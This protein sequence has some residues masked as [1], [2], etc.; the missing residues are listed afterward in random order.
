M[1]EQ[2]MSEA[3]E[4]IKSASEEELRDLVKKWFERTRTD[5]MRLG[6]YLISA[7]VFDTID[8]NLTDGNNSS[9]RDYKRA[10][11]KVV[12]ILSVQLKQEETVQNDLEEN[13]DDGTAE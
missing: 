6:A 8:K 7:T 9:L 10:I 2:N 3:I 5:G 12:E 4:K 11:K 1:T 13:T